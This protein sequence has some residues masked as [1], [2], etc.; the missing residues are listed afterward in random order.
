MPYDTVMMADVILPESTYLERH[1]ALQLAKGAS[2]SVSIRQPAVEPM[3]ESKPG[4]WIAK[5]L[6]TRLGLGEHFPYAHYQEYIKKQC[7]V[8]GVDYEQLRTEGT[9]VVPNSANPYIG[10]DNQPKFRTPSGKIE[11][12]SKR[13]KDE[14]FDPVPKYEPVEQPKEGWFRLLAGRTSVHTFSRTTDNQLLWELFRENAVWL[15]SDEAKKRGIK[16]GDYVILTNQD[17]VRSNRVRAKVTERIR[18]DCVF[19]V[20]GFGSQSKALTQVYNKGADDNKLFSKFTV[21]PISGATGMRVNFVQIE[22]EA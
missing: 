2:L 12:Y 1:D 9:I 8:M 22:K 3:Y 11:L 16:N 4:W 10:L 21:D 20:H 19:M 17:G 5:E 6:G 13:L 7:A 18:G 15:N 14:G